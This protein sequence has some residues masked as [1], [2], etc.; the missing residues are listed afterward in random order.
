[1]LHPKSIAIVGAS[2]DANKLNGRPFHFLRRDGYKGKL[3][4]VN[5]KY[6]EIDGVRC[7]PDVESLPEAPDLAIIAVSQKLAAAAIAA[8][9]QKGTPVAIIFS[10]GYSELGAE[11]AK[12]EQELLQTAQSNNIRICGP[13]NLG[14]INAFENVTAT[15]S[16]YADKTPIPGPVAFASQSGAFGTGI[17]ALA[18]GRG[19]GLGYFINTGNQ[20]DITLIDAL[21]EIADDP[22]ITVLSAYIEG[23]RDGTE[24]IHLAHKALDLEKPLIITKVGRKAAGARAAASHTGSLAGEDRVFDGVLRQ[25][26]VIRARNEE[27][28]LDLVSA[29]TCCPIPKGNGLAMITQSGGAGVL[30]ADRAEELGLE[31]PIPTP[32]TQ[33]KL[34]SVIP[35]FGS[36]SNPIDVTGQFL[37]EPKILSESV[38]IALDDP[39]IHC[40][41]V[42]LQLLHGSADLLVDVFKGIQ[43]GVDK[44]FIVCWLEAPESA[45]R[46]LRDA[47]ICVIGATERAVDAIAGLVQ[48][49]Q[50]RARHDGQPPPPSAHK[51]EQEPEQAM[52]IPSVR[53]A[54]LL[55]DMG[56]P[57]ASAELATGPDAARE[58][59]D[60]FGYP[61]AIKIESPDILHKT[62]AGGV[63]LGLT[64][65][66]S[67]VVA[68]QEIMTAARAYNPA[69]KIEGLIVQRMV[70][71]ATELVLGVRRDPVFGPVVMVGLGGIFVEILEDVAF[72]AAP[73][74][75]R[76]AE[77][78]LNGLQGRAILDGV[79]GKPPVDLH[80]LIQVICD[81]SRFAL[82][83]PEIVELDL[84]PVFADSNGIIA[85]DWM[86]MCGTPNT[87]NRKAV[88]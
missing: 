84:N 18:R 6:A 38:K 23:L 57:L 39:G 70:K 77:L 53:A 13:N 34:Q 61:V 82:A 16:Q 49:S 44:P 76:Q 78:M 29:F 19:I 46:Q 5:P 71:P 59:A 25:H 1:M 28:M 60:R 47:G 69:A 4:P 37:A 66:E 85:V 12:L 20:A 43:T 58:I 81:L 14:L 48:Y 32:E 41:I 27:H 15:F 52:A 87:T 8:L 50:A 75:A 55:E 74:T 56:I 10:S 7:Y 63:R 79:R 72:A 26:G 83:H 11:G 62:E 80:A 73:V 21:I 33:A 67:V 24:L 17:A 31:V 45:L 88:P 9:G 68:S 30:M 35:S 40:C 54:K 2:S 3:Y 36:A 51:N 65:G 22:R 64:D 86:M 42:W